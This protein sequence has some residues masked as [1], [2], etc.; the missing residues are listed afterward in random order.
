M[1]NKKI[2]NG[3]HAYGNALPGWE[4]HIMG[5]RPVNGMAYPSDLNGVVNPAICKMKMRRILFPSARTT[6]LGN[7][8]YKE[9][10]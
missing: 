2:T 6:N 9:K 5:E 4:G 7:K 3:P 1:G 10:L 8:Y